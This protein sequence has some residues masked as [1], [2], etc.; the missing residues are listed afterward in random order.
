MKLKNQFPMK[1]PVPAIQYDNVYAY[2]YKMWNISNFQKS[3]GEEWMRLLLLL[4]GD[5]ERN[6]GPGIGELLYLR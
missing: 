3:S 4:A 5:I 2:L 6:P 1:I